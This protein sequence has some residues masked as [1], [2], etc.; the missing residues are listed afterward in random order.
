MSPSKKKMLG[1]VC[2]SARSGSRNKPPLVL[3]QRRWNASSSALRALALGGLG[4]APELAL[5]LGVHPGAYPPQNM[6][7]PPNRP[8]ENRCRYALLPVC[9]GQWFGGYG[10]LQLSCPSAKL[11]ESPDFCAIL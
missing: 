3:N 8:R 4:H 10:K 9:E 1:A 5:L 7:C 2:M 6:E 11:N